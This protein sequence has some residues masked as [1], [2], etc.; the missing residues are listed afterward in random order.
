[1]NLIFAG[2]EQ[3]NRVICK[4]IYDRGFVYSFWLCFNIDAKSLQYYF[5]IFFIA[6]FGNIS[7]KRAKIAV[8]TFFS[9]P[10]IFSLMMIRAFKWHRFWIWKINLKFRLAAL[11]LGNLNFASEHW[12]LSVLY[13]LDSGTFCISEEINEQSFLFWKLSFLYSIQIQFKRDLFACIKY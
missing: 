13:C 2:Y 5:R 12:F 7:Q 1:M 11:L 9:W 6:V 4:Q 10:L 8:A 3:Q